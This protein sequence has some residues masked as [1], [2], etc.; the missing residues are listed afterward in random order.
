MR[1]H[2]KHILTTVLT[3]YYSY[4][5]HSVNI[6]AVAETIL[7]WKFVRSD[8]L[9][10]LLEENGFAY[11]ASYIGSFREIDHLLLRILCGVNTRLYDVEDWFLW[12]TSKWPKATRLRWVYRRP[13]TMFGDI[14]EVYVLQTTQR[15]IP[16][17]YAL[18]VVWDIAGGET[19]YV[20]ETSRVGALLYSFNFPLQRGC[21]NECSCC[22]LLLSKTLATGYLNIVENNFYRVITQTIELPKT[23]IDIMMNAG[24]LIEFIEKLQNQYRP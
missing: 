22:S 12:A 13:T 16:C 23:H 17:K 1:D 18:L 2:L 10:S 24:R 5:R 9:Q 14:G 11:L 20:G 15:R 3:S 21:S 8:W 19:I 4:S 6:T 7:P